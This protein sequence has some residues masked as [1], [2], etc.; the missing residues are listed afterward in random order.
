MATVKATKEINLA[1]TNGAA[2]TIEMSEPYI[3]RATIEG[4]S[5]ILFHRWNDEAVEIKAKANKNSA[6]KKTDDLES[7]V[8]RNDKNEICIPGAYLAGAIITSAK[9]RQD[10]RSSRKSAM[11]LYKASVLALTDLAPIRTGGKTCKEW[12]FIDRRRVT[13]QRAGITRCR[14][15]FS[16]GWQATFDMLV[17]TPEY[18]SPHDLHD[19]IVNAGKLI[20]IADFRPTFGRFMVT[21]WEVVK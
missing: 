14:P 19:V 6:G 20:G 2:S 4:T 1:P 11:D 13:I 21:S 3:V 9:F 12:E 10:P 16:A 17:Q 8:Y 7:Y 15:G 5:A 18:I